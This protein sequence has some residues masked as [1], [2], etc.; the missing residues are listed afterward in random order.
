M[1]NNQQ[2]TT[3]KRA[4]ILDYKK[5]KVLRQVAKNVPLKDI[6]TKKIGDVI[7]KMKAALHGEEDGVAIAAPQIG[8][9]LRIFIISGKAQDMYR[10]ADKK[11]HTREGAKRRDDLVFINPEIIKLSK[12]K[13]P[14]D[15]GCLSVR[16]LYGQ[17]ERHEKAT[18]KA[19]D[20]KG[21]RFE[22]GGSG[23]MAQIFQHETDHLDGVLFI[24]KAKNVHKLSPAEN[25]L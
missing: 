3:N 18:V 13:K 10:G 11:L 15:E 1:T 16:W 8:A 21:K 22:M 4:R 7:A 5:S 14:M 9:G 23:L 25:D 20:E 17:V 6:G 19:Y 24:D 2:P 12:K